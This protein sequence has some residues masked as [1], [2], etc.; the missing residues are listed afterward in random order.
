MRVL[1]TGHR[2]YIGS[3]VAAVLRN[4]G[5]D[6]VGWDSDLYGDCDFGR[7]RGHVPCFDSDLRD[8]EFTDLLSF[9]AV[10]H[11]AGLSDSVGADP[12]PALLNEVNYEATIRL[13]ECCH[14][15][16]V[17]RLVFA[18]SCS[19]Y[20]RGGA[21]ELDENGAVQPLTRYARSKLAAERDLLVQGDSAL[22]KVVLRLAT[23]YGVSPRLRLDLAV[24]DFV[25]SA[26]TTGRVVLRTAGAA[27][28]PFVHVEDV[29]RT[30][31][32]VLTAPDASVRGQVFNV[33]PCGENY[34]I[35]DVADLVCECDPFCT[36]HV[37]LHGY[38]D[39]NY[40]ADGSKLQGTFPRL[41]LKWTLPLGIRQLF[42][43]FRRAGLTAAEWRSDRY[44]RAARLQSTLERGEL[45]PNLRRTE[46]GVQAQGL[47]LQAS[48]VEPEFTA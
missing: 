40:Q 18:S 20:G 47:R 4:A 38:D 5:C 14:R 43:A 9:D 36:R 6:V 24:N 48:G 11:L 15:A 26:V 25:G 23:V 29:A 16:G 17:D 45:L 44:R 33:L 12:D 46:L 28:R 32:A 30:C 8:V 21:G 7:I 1:V 22:T 42:A 3:V 31:L 39:R 10:I 19:V 2:G 41:A 13:A 27:W 37:N 35:V 34:R